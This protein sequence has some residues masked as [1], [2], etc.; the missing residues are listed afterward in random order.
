METEN[1]EKVEKEFL[2]RRDGARDLSFKGVWLASSSTRKN[3]DVR[4]DEYHLYKTAAG[5]F[6]FAMESHSLYEDE[7]D[8]YRAEIYENLASFLKI[9][10]ETISYSVLKNLAMQLNIDISE[11]I[12]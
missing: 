11:H 8:E 4:W 2:V 12:D 5:K 1:K 6:V 10:E 9:A 7:E 3:N